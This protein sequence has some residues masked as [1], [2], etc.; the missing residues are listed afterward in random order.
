VVYEFGS[1]FVLNVKP[2]LSSLLGYSCGQI[3]VLTPVTTDDN[4]ISNQELSAF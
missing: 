1:I 4:F 3:I 2:A